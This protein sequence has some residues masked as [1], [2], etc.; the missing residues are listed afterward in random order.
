E[1]VADRVAMLH[2]GRVVFSA[3]LED[4]K[5]THRC[6]TVR[7]AES[8]PRPPALAGALTWTGAGHE[9]TAVVAGRP[10]GLPAAVAAWGGRGGGEAG[11]GGAPWV[12]EIFA[13]GV[14]GAAEG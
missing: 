7:F 11:G 5:E 12:D 1:R 8:R 10:G 4:V 3:D 14:G 6:L 2:A 13:A 9:W